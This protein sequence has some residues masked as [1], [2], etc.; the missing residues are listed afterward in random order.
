MKYV[1]VLASLLTLVSCESKSSSKSKKCTYNDEPIDC[2]SMN[3]SHEEKSFTLVSKVKSEISIVD[4]KIETLENTENVESK[5]R[6]GYVY[7]CKT[8]TTAGNIFDYNV[9]GKT[10]QLKLG[11]AI[12]SLTR[13]SGESKSIEGSWR[14]VDKDETGSST[15]TITFTKNTMDLTVQCFFK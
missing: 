1:L 6:N 10:L 8:S 2:S 12:E 15:V 13:V 7:D 5:I 3:A 14:K 11:N 4:N 9:I